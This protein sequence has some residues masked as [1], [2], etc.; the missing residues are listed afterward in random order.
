MNLSNTSIHN[1]SFN[2]IAPNE[3]ISQILDHCI[4]AINIFSKRHIVGALV[5]TGSFSR[6][7]GSI[8]YNSEEFVQIMGDI[9][10]FVV[11]ERILDY[12]TLQ[13][14]LSL[15][16]SEAEQKLEKQQILCK[17]E[18]SPVSRDYFRRAKPSIF[19][20][21]LKTHGKV[22]F[23]D[24]TLLQEIPTYS[25]ASIP[26]V[27]GFYLLCNR[28]VEQL[29]ALKS[30]QDMSKDNRYQIL[31][32]YLDLAGSYLVVSGRYAPTYAER[33]DLCSDA[34]LTDNILTSTARQ[35]QFVEILREATD[36]KLNPSS[37]DCHLMEGG[38]TPENYWLLFREAASFCRDIWQWEIQKLYGISVKETGR[39]FST[40]SGFKFRFIFRDWVKFF[41]M[42]HRAGRKVSLYRSFCQF[43]QG[44]PRTLIYAAAAYLFFSLA[45]DRPIDTR[46]IERLLPLSCNLNSTDEAIDSVIDAWIN[47]VRSA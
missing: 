29:I 24:K 13:E 37:A 43:R 21:E 33:V 22:V 14:G 4:A 26:S 27:D 17:I 3:I 11:F 40:N 23:G 12:S 35:Q 34:L 8:C 18:F 1:A 47:F 39:Q 5:L 6:G 7:E 44:T 19:N 36:Y 10:F 45:E 25:A 46:V 38:F 31:K 41:L 42:A 20:F 15:C 32:L 16:A 30:L 2:P 28:I 9:E